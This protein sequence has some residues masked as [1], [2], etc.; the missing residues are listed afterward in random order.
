MDGYE[1]D[2]LQHCDADAPDI[3]L[4]GMNV[5]LKLAVVVPE[6]EWGRIPQFKGILPC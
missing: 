6:A 4:G 5:L 1:Q 3:E 2:E